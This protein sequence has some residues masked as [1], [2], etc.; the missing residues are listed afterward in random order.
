MAAEFA[1]Q[2]TSFNVPWGV[3][4]AKIW[5]PENGKP[6]LGLHGWLDNANTFDKLVP[7]LPKNIRF[8]AMDFAGHSMSSHRPLGI[9][10]SNF[11]YVA[12]VKK[13]VFQLGWKQFSIIGHSMGGYVAMLYAGCFPD[14]VENLILIDCGGPRPR[15]GNRPAEVLATYATKMASIKPANPRVYESVEKAAVRR[16]ETEDT[17]PYYPL[18]KESAL[19]ITKRGTKV[20]NEGVI[21]SHDPVIRGLFRPF[22]SPEVSIKLIL[23]RIKSS[24][25]VLEGTT[26]KIEIEVRERPILLCQNAKFLM[27]KKVEG[28]HHFHMDNPEQTAREIKQFFMQQES[29]NI[30]LFSS[31][32]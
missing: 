31:K 26:S 13:V 4:A 19:S 2:E 11:E 1:G 7:L 15:F 17:N 8:I 25:L 30:D 21:F 6:F 22:I 27:K 23:Y 14:E 5:G 12:D 24:M 32:L 16:E 9:G 18:S 3:I 10:Y 20:T 29:Q 28:G